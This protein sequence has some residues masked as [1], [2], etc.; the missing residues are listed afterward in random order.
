M[1]K[2]TS[3]MD[4]LTSFMDDIASEYQGQWLKLAITVPL[5]CRCHRMVFYIRYD[6]GIYR[7]CDVWVKGDSHTT[8]LWPEPQEVKETTERFMDLLGKANAKL[9]EEYGI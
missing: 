6:R 8:G 2:I 3:G 7:L 9:K 1:N 4:V 5:H